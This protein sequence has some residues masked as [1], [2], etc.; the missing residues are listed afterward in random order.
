MPSA[1]IATITR[2]VET[3]PESLQ[4]H[5]ADHLREYI[6]ELLDEMKWEQ[7]FSRSQLQLEAMEQRASQEIEKRESGSIFWMMT[8][9]TD[10][11]A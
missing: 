7:A 11:D 6:Q 1:G 3:L 4:E 2:M 8:Y 9:A 5:V 10:T